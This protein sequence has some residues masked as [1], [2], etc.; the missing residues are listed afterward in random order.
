M[1]RFKQDLNVVNQKTGAI[2]K[3]KASGRRDPR[4]DSGGEQ[5][6]YPWNNEGGRW[7]DV[8]LFIRNEDPQCAHRNTRFSESW[9]QRQ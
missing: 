7:D 3:P 6:D 9:I 2:P 1:K 5:A 4:D 8:S